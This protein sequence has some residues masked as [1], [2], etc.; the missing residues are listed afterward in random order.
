MDREHD[1]LTCLAT[2]VFGLHCRKWN[3]FVFTSAICWMISQIM[4]VS[5]SFLNTSSIAWE[6]CGSP[7]LD[8]AAAAARAALLV[9]LVYA[10]LYVSTQWYGCQCLGFLMCKQMLVHVI[11]HGGYTNT[12]RW[13]ALKDDYA[14][15]M[16]HCKLQVLHVFVTYQ[17]T[18]LYKVQSYTLILNLVIGMYSKEVNWFLI[19]TLWI[20][21][22]VHLRCCFAAKLIKFFQ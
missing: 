16:Q 7:Y 18:Y 5:S 13:L 19:Y 11:E 20:V 15:S 3:F 10:V 22:M 4:C 9:L 2:D 17:K 8:T 6:K 21:E 14:T 1:I 12:V